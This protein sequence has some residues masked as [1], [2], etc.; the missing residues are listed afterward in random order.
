MLKP[1]RM[2]ACR[3]TAGRLGG[4][5]PG[6]CSLKTCMHVRPIRNSKTAEGLSASALCP[7]GPAIAINWRF[8]WGVM[9]ASPKD[10]RDVR[11]IVI[12]NIQATITFK[13]GK[14]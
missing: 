2:V 9:L 4:V 14:T 7:C 13:I 3:L 8:V 10:S 12:E 11:E 6:F 5:I 1:G